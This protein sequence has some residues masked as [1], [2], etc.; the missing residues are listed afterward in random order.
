MH[1]G[2]ESLPQ[3]SMGFRSE[4]W[5]GIVEPPR[6][7]PGTIF[8]GYLRIIVLLVCP[9]GAKMEI[10]CRLLDIALQNLDV[11][12]L[13]HNSLYFYNIT[14]PTCRETTPQHDAPTSKFHSRHSVLW[15]ECFTFLAP[16]EGNIPVTKQL[17][18]RLV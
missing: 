10:F 8:F 12:L 9:V 4:L 17:H 7:Y 15:V 13:L 3:I 11:L 6:C 14:R 18:F 5:L 2:R 16:N 1:L